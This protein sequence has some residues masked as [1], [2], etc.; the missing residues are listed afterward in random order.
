MF[1]DNLQDSFLQLGQFIAYGKE[2]EDIEQMERPTYN[3][4]YADLTTTFTILIGIF[5]PSVTG[6]FTV[7]SLSFQ[8]NTF[9]HGAGIIVCIEIHRYHGWVQPIWRLGR[10]A[11]EHPYR[12]HWCYLDHLH[13]VSV[14]RNA[15]CWNR[16]Q[17]AASRQVRTLYIFPFILD[18]VS[19]YIQIRNIDIHFIFQV[20][21]IYRWQT[22]GS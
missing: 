1:F 11:E 21:S 7:P 22:G 8:S 3:Q 14:L 6:K 4:I 13:G 16:R 17:L 15:L 20:R 10:R 5:F 19:P 9:R 12:N 2:P 18:L